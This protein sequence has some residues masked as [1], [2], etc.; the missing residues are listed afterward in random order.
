MLSLPSGALLTI[1]SWR[2][3]IMPYLLDYSVYLSLQSNTKTQLSDFATKIFWDYKGVLEVSSV[4]LTKLAVCCLASAWY[5]ASW[6]QTT[7][8]DWC[9]GLS[10]FC[11]ENSS[12]SKITQ[13]D[14]PDDSVHLNFSLMCDS[15]SCKASH[16]HVVSM[17]RILKA[18]LKLSTARYLCSETS[19]DL[20]VHICTGTSCTTHLTGSPKHAPN[21]LHELCEGNLICFA[22]E[23]LLFTCDTVLRAAL[24]S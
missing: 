14:D 23:C 20:V 11:R 3:A 6:L 7:Q 17:M 12:V 9:T 18:N 13:P 24:K 19:K 22:P 21:A 4:S 8:L 2:C 16:A 5:C 15:D 10:G 1:T